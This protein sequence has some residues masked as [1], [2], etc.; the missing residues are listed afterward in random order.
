MNGGS[1]IGAIA[2]VEEVFSQVRKE[3]Q[4]GMGELSVALRVARSDRFGTELEDLKSVLG[5]LWCHSMVERDKL[6][7]VWDDVVGD[8]EPN[9]VVRWEDEDPEENGPIDD[10]SPPPEAFPGGRLPPPTQSD[11]PP[12]EVK[13]LSPLPVQAPPS[14]E[15]DEWESRSYAPVNARS[16]AYG[17]QYL[18]LLRSDGVADVLD[19][20]GTVEQTVR[21][22]FFLAPVYQRRVM[23]HAKLLILIDQQG[24]MVPFHRYG[25]DVV[26]TAQV[27]GLLE[28]VGVYYFRNVPG[29]VVFEDEH[30]TQPQKLQ[31]VLED[32]DRETSVLIISDAGAARGTR[33]MKRL[34]ETLKFL[35]R[36]RQYTEA[37]SWLNPM[38][39]VRWWGTSAELLAGLVNMEPMDQSGF[40]DSIARLRGDR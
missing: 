23:N 39:K 29:D 11:P 37:V 21:Q 35:A 25:R 12:P 33:Q 31:L 32:C 17:W 14:W 26:Q 22:G 16:L 36:V 24:S 38:P 30:L 8:R 15:M 4:L 13:Q 3:F 18:R 28:S 9:P 5:L 6:A 1:P 19:V 34:R 40:E 20:E 2:V 27:D 10:D 7:R